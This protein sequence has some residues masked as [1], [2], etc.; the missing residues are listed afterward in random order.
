MPANILI[1]VI[2]DITGTRTLWYYGRLS[3]EYSSSITITLIDTANNKQVG[4]P[5]TSPIRYTLLNMHDNIQEVMEHMI[6]DLPKK[7]EDYWNK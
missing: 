2:V 4:A 5:I 1:Y 7:I 3:Y 6:T